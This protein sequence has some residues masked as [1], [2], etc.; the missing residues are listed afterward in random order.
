[1]NYWWVNHKQTHKAEIE[2]GYIW[3]PYRN[4]KGYK[5]PTYETLRGVKPGD[6]ILSFYNKAVRHYGVVKTYKYSFPKPKG[7]DKNWGEWGWRCDVRF[8]NLDKPVFTQEKISVLRKHLRKKHNPIQAQTGAGNQ[9][10]YLAK[11]TEGMIKEIARLSG[12]DGL[13][14]AIK[15]SLCRA[16]SLDNIQYKYNMLDDI[17]I[18]MIELRGNSDANKELLQARY[19]IGVYREKVAALEK[20]CRITAAAC[21]PALSACHIKPWREADDKEKL[22]GTNGLLLSPG[23]AQMFSYGFF[24]FSYDGEVIKSSLLEEDSPLAGN[25]PSN[26]KLKKKFNGAQQDFLEHHRNYVLLEAAE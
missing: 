15:L 26:A 5:R 24:S 16:S 1:M 7:F 20:V 12:S 22:E 10:C 25:I 9:P 8:Y 3:C 4:S 13:Q 23:T 21:H 6:V 2:D 18:S 17:Q 19:G 14:Q 11:I